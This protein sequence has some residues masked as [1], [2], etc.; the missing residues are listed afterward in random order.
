MVLVDSNVLLDVMTDDP[1]WY[2]WSVGQ[3]NG[4]AINNELAINDIIYSELA[5]SF[6]RFEE[7]SLTVEDMGLRLRPMP[8]A[9]LFLAGK[10]YRSYRRAGGMK[11][12]VLPDFF[13]GAQAAVEALP[14]LTR[15]IRRYS[16]Y[17]PTVDLI[18]P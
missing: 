11:T 9:A 18:T 3:M 4:L 5:P 6:S 1:V 15:D 10:V 2:G 12:G 13:I 7:L 17:F 14:V 8:R 16:T